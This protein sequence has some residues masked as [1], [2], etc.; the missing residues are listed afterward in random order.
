MNSFKLLFLYLSLVL[1]Y[2]PTFHTP[3]KIK[4]LD[5]RGASASFVVN[6]YC[7]AIDTIVLINLLLLCLVFLLFLCVFLCWDRL[8]EGNL[9]S[10]PSINHPNVKVHFFLG[11]GGDKIS[12]ISISSGEYIL[13]K[14]HSYSAK[15]YFLFFPS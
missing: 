14:I 15:K 12:S 3:K 1:G 4:I 11:G 6:C 9:P 10:P 5:A 2:F 8:I 13:H 7:C